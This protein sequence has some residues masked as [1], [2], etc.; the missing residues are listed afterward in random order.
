MSSVYRGWVGGGLGG[1]G[2]GGGWE[3]EGRFFQTFDWKNW[4]STEVHKQP[5][6]TCQADTVTA[7]V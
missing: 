6:F 3:A 7:A 1:V 4:V 5:Q 2:G